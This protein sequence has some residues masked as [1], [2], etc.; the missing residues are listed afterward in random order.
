MKV[1]NLINNVYQFLNL[2]IAPLS[3]MYVAARYLCA[4]LGAVER[5]RPALGEYNVRLKMTG[6][7]DLGSLGYQP[8]IGKFGFS[9]LIF[10]FVTRHLISRSTE[11][12]NC[13]RDNQ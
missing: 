13:G 1:I 3:K 7:R 6:T 4:L 9:G 12:T 11:A 5:I 10:T 8:I 2:V